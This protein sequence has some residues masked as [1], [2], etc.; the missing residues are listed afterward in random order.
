VLLIVGNTIRLDIQ[1]RRDEI[2]IIKLIGGTDAFIRRPFLYSGL[3]YGLFGGIIAWVLIE[4]S[5]GLLAGPV[6]RLAV[7]Y[8]SD[9]SLTTLDF[10]TAFTLLEIST[11]LGLGGSWIAV[12]QHLS[13]I[14]P[15]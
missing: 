1:N 4:I 14:E 2:I 8:G 12:G 5:L 11:V 9:F 13:E 6:D 3:W 7:L 15:T 10:S